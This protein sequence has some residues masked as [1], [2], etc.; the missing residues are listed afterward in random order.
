MAKA[1]ILFGNNRMHI[2]PSVSKNRD[3]MKSKAQSASKRGSVV[4]YVTKRVLFF[5]S[6]VE[7]SSLRSSVAGWNAAVH[8]CR[9]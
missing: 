5:A 3:V 1:L 6:L 7:V 8:A 9:F 4:F 2:I